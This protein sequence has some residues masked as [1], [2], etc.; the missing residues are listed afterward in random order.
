LCAFTEV[1]IP[2]PQDPYGISKWH[3]EQELQ[4][5]AHETGLEIVIVRPPLVYGPGVKG[6]FISLFSAVYRGL[7]LPLSGADNARSLVYVGNLVDAL[8]TC[9]THPA[10]VG[11]SYLVS[12]GIAVSTS[13]LIERIAQALGCRSRLFYFPPSLLRIVAV[14]LRRSAQVDRLF[15]SLRVNDNKIRKDLNWTPP[16]TLEQGLKAT[17]QWYREQF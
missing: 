17:A 10:A 13:E 8:L 15:S 6:N 5:I 16:Y 1:D 9:A 12:D 2:D 4:R 7:P 3:A 11:N 14:L